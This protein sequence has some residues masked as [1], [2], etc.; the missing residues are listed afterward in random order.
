MN[1]FFV[2]MGL[3][4]TGAIIVG[5]SYLIFICICDIANILKT[6][7]KIKHRFNKTPTAKCY[8]RDCKYWN[9][10]YCTCNN[11]RG[12]KTA[13]NWFCCDASPV[14]QIKNEDNKA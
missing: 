14:K 2:T 7:H 12:L 3:L 11:L 8:C 4:A 10:L 1:D 6:R 5:V 13:D 9:A